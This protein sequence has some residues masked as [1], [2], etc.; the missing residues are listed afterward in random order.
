M[1]VIHELVAR[2]RKCY[3]SATIMEVAW[4]PSVV[5]DGV[6]AGACRCSCHLLDGIGRIV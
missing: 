3:G 2:L 5:D 6:V 4:L 1:R